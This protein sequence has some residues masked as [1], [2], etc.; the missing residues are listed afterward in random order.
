MSPHFALKGCSTNLLPSDYSGPGTLLRAWHH[1]A[2][3]PGNGLLAPDLIWLRAC[4]GRDVD[5]E[6]GRERFSC[7]H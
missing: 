2:S 5:R 7:E 3:G 6:S 4:C 1:I